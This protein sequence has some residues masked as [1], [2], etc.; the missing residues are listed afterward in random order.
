MEHLDYLGGYFWS[1]HLRHAEVE[2][3]QFEHLPMA[4]SDTF[5]ALRDNVESNPAS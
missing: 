5:Y 1:V 4:E 3:D 2:E